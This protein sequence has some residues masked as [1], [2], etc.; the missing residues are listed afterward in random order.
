MKSLKTIKNRYDATTTA[1]DGQ[2]KSLI[3][4]PITY[5][6]AGAIYHKE[7]NL[8][9]RLEEELTALIEQQE[10]YINSGLIIN[11]TIFKYIENKIKDKQTNLE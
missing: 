7:I 8:K 5:Q 11:S 4:T 1:M 9:D 10:Q 3:T 2:S 6:Q